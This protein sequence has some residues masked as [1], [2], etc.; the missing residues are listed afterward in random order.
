MDPVSALGVAAAALQFLDAFTKAYH[1]FREIRNSTTL[2]TERSQQLEENIRCTQSLRDSLRD[3]LK[4]TST[5][6]GAA[7]DPVFT[8]IARCTSKADELLTLL[9]YVRGTRNNSVAFIRTWQKRNKI[10]GLYSSLKEDQ[11]T[12]NQMLSQ[13]HL[14]EIER[15]KLQQ[16]NEFSNLNSMGQRLINEQIEHRKA[17]EDS[18][19][20]IVELGGHINETY[21]ST[22][23]NELC[24][25]LWFRKIDQRQSEIKEPAPSTLDWLFESISDEHS[26][27]DVTWSNFKQWLRE[28]TS[29][30]WISGKAGSGKSTLIAH[31]VNDPRTLEELDVWSNGHKLEILSFFFWRAGSQIQN[32]VSGLLRSLLYQLCHLEDAIADTVISF[33]SS[34]TR[35]KTTGTL[36]RLLIPAWRDRHLLECISKAIQSSQDLRF[37]IFIDGLDEFTG[38]YD[39]LVDL[40]EQLQRFH[41]VKF[42][43]SSRP[44]LEL[45]ERFRGL[46]T[47]RLQDLN[48]GDIEKFVN[49]S[50]EKTKLSE[51]Y[52]VRLSSDVVQ[53]AEGV[54]LWA[55]LVTQSLVKG[56]KAG[57]N[58]EIM[59]QRLNSLPRDMHQLFEQMLSN[60]DPVYRRE[61][62]PFY[63]ELMKLSTEIPAVEEIA[64]IATI[65][66]ARL[67]T[68]ING[69]EEFVNQCERT[70]IQIA[71]QSAGLLEICTWGN[72]VE[73][74]W[75]RVSIKSVSNQPCF[76]PGARGLNRGR[77]PEDEPYPIVLDYEARHMKWIHRSAFEFVSNLPNM[78]PL[79]QLS[80]SR[81]ELL[82]QIGNSYI[83]YMIDAPSFVDPLGKWKA[84]L[85]IIRF[86]NLLFFASS[87]YRSYPLAASALL[88]KFHDMYIQWDQDELRSTAYNRRHHDIHI[89][90]RRFWSICGRSGLWPY[91]LSREDRILKEPSCDVIMVQL[92]ASSFESP[93]GPGYPPNSPYLQYRDF[94]AR[95]WLRCTKNSL[96]IDGFPQT[97]EYECV[98]LR[99]GRDRPNYRWDIFNCATWKEPV[100]GKSTA[101]LINLITL[102][103]SLWLRSGSYSNTSLLMPESLSTFMKVKDLYVAPDIT[104]DRLH[105]HISTEALLA[106]AY[107][108]ARRSTAGEACE[109]GHMGKHI[110][111]IQFSRAIRVVCVPSLQGWRMSDGDD[112]YK[113]RQRRPVATAPGPSKFIYFQP[114]IVT[115]DHLLRLLGYGFRSEPRAKSWFEIVPHTQQQWEEM[116]T[117]LLEDIK[118]PE[119]GLD[120]GQQ[121]I[122]AAC[123][124]ASFLKPHADNLS[125][126]DGAL[127]K[128]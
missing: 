95:T 30:Y 68:Q 33:L 22:M 35:K 73:S 120:G 28:D 127:P 76:T 108:L 42:C 59:Q 40:I 37:C 24:D 23:R 20:I 9:T 57:D 34:P 38:S 90:R 116:C 70:Q 119:Q 56:S 17:Q 7:T 75:R 26:S 3:S 115:S 52:R 83:G 85:T 60:T 102:L 41:N 107:D 54:F 43:V 126:G 91:V 105:I 6:Q 63:I 1:T 96:E 21:R 104:F 87:W 100:I 97:A 77:Y 112:E 46:K 48:R 86:D 4:S 113:R 123:V 49:Q 125:S 58:A 11:D 72:V 64:H 61:S 65:T 8:L 66:I 31:I 82:Q 14:P 2:S 19:A 69:Y 98:I 32:S 15:V 27:L 128:H 124:K 101:A 109:K 25:S 71:T 55:S 51:D 94:L 74:D 118:S 84:P 18:H 16:S 88:D 114:S 110:S 67:D 50:L 5:P 89:G 117:M 47:L 103:G 80:V 12:L 111:A 79:F 29:T 121:L 106:A 81:E 62:L 92:L 44:E 93:D 78:N 99:Y 10:E 122:A 36:P 45:A 13:R 39:H 53:R